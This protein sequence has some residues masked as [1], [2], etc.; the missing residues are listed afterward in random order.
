MRADLRSMTSAEQAPSTTSLVAKLQKR[1]AALLQPDETILMTLRCGALDLIEPDGLL[2]ML[3]PI[4]RRMQRSLASDQLED[5]ARRV[6]IHLQRRGLEPAEL[7]PSR[8]GYVVALS[9]KRVLLFN[10][11][12][13][14]FLSDS[15]VRMYL[16]VVRIGD[17]TIL[18]FME[19]REAAAVAVWDDEYDASA[20]AQKY[21][22]RQLAGARRVS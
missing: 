17:S 18:L 13:R 1:H 16:D 2:G 6:Q 19:G 12:G 22:E 21:R 15:P 11:S 7:P 9:D 14:K 3:G 4:G 20:F 10:A 5:R 8:I